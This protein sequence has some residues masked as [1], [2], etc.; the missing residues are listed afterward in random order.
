MAYTDVPALMRELRA[1]EG[2]AARALELTDPHS[3][4]LWG[5]LERHLDRD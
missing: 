5:N 3:W 1:R 2:L 4:A